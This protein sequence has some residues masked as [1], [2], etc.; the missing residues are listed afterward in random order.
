MVFEE[1]KKIILINFFVYIFLFFSIGLLLYTH[2]KSY[3]VFNST[4]LNHYLFYYY[5]SLFSIISFLILS[6]LNVEIKKNILLFLFTLIFLAYISEIFVRVFFKNSEKTSIENNKTIRENRARIILEK[7][8]QVVDTRSPLQVQKDLKEKDIEAFLLVT[9]FR[10]IGTDGIKLFDEKIDTETNLNRIYPLSGISKKLYVGG[11]ESGE[12]KF[13]K[14]DRYGF[15]N[16]D[17]DWDKEI[18]I[19]LIG[20]SFTHGGYLDFKDNFTG[21]IKKISKKPVLGL[22]QPNNGPLLELATLKEYAKK[23]KPKIVIWMYY[24]GNDLIELVDE[25]KS[26]TLVKYLNNDFQQSLME[27]QKIIEKSYTKFV[28][29]TISQ[30][31]LN[32]NK[33]ETFRLSSFIK[34]QKLREIFLKLLISKLRDQENYK[35]ISYLNEVLAEAKRETDLLGAKLYFAYL[36]SSFRFLN[37]Q[38]ALKKNNF[39][40]EEVLDIVNNLEINLIDIYDLIFK[41]HKNPLSFYHFSMVSHYN[42]KAV[43]EISLEIYKQIDNK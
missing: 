14:T 27:K 21:V 8:G 43:E 35:S 36:P 41:S 7:Y 32:E 37:D 18:Y 12:Y 16:F 42:K 30:L 4:R 29:E 11:A 25:K 3:F 26:K 19:A 31:D 10:M 5:F 20:D 22:A 9:P 40:R 6:F 39:Y 23:I 13:Y 17:D 33:T 2:Y 28:N 15:N 24:E 34:L 38:H 1:K